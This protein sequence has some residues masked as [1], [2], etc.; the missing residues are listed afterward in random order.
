MLRTYLKTL[1]RPVALLALFALAAC[2]AAD[3]TSQAP[4][5]AMVS[6]LMSGLGAV[7]PK[8]KPIDYKPR[9]PLAMPAEP[10]ALPK[11]ETKVAG[12]QS[13][14]WPA[15]QKNDDFDAVKALYA[16]KSVGGRDGNENS[17]LTPEQARGINIY[18]TKSR[19]PVA[20]KRQ[21]ELDDGD[22]MTPEEMRQQNTTAGELKKQAAGS[23]QDTLSQRRYLIEPPSEYST[24]AAGAPMPEVTEV[25]NTTERVSSEIACSGSNRSLK[26]KDYQR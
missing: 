24:P 18:S 11:P 14:N 9:A 7:D 26:C 2:Q 3:G 4:D 21:A 13:D 25:D 17:R 20:E 1:S 23:T 22:R 10:T 6:A 19:D 16:K 15:A 12:S 5:T 8:A